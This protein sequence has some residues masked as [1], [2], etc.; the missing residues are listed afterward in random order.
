MQ[1]H[2][3]YRFISYILIPVAA[4]FAAADLMVLMTALRNPPFLLPVFM[5]AC[6]VI[7]VFS[8]FSFLNKGILQAKP[9]KP[10]L[11]DFIKVNAIVTVVFATLM[12]YQT[13][14]ALTDDKLLADFINQ[15]MAMQKNTSDVPKETMLKAI[16][17]FLYFLGIF[18]VLLVIHIVMTFRLLKH[19]RHVFGSLP[20]DP[21]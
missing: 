9:R 21:E 19:Y 13:V 18:S 12:L 6:V 11:K 4:L 15:V 7:Y 16:K 20:N 14:A 2:T 5:I 1:K 8:S 17:A 3:L 10:S